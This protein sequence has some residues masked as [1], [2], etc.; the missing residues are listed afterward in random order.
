MP[1]LH[2]LT[3]DADLQAAG[4]V[5][6]RLLKPVAELSSG[7]PAAKIQPDLW[8]NMSTMKWFSP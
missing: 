2:W 1:T 7:D 6:Y 3:R 8:Y 4:R 5:P